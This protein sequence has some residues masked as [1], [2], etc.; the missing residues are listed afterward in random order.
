MKQA[1]QIEL[2]IGARH[3]YMYCRLPPTNPI[4]ALVLLP[5]QTAGTNL[6]TPRGW[7]AGLARACVYVHDLLRVITRRS[8]QRLKRELNPGQRSQ[9]PTRYQWTYRTVHYRVRI[10]C[11]KTARSAVWVEPTIFRTPTSD[12]DKDHI[13]TLFRSINRSLCALIWLQFS[14]NLPWRIYI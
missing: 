1:Q 11:R 4:T 10:K 9:D 5:W 7:I 12:D 6:P 3:F 8:N 2:I 14:G 13:L